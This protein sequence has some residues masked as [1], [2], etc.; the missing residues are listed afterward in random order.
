MSQDHYPDPAT[1][2]AILNRFRATPA[3]IPVM[4]EDS[5]A[6]RAVYDRMLE[7]ERQ[8]VVRPERLTFRPYA[9]DVE[10]NGRPL[11]RGNRRGF[12]AAFLVLCQG[13]PVE[14]SIL[15]PS[16]SGA[17]NS[18]RWTARDASRISPVLERA[19]LSIGTTNRHLVL[20]Q[21]VHGIE[22]R[23]VDK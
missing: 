1:A 9:V 19:I 15:Y 2:R 21:P 12:M 22:A 23:F 18:L 5:P 8:H 10:L 6:A 4:L 11:P 7:R 13:P 16:R 3:L 20:R 17:S 14:W